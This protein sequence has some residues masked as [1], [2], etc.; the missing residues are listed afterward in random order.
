MSNATQ[1]LARSGAWPAL[2]TTPHTSDAGVWVMPVDELGVATMIAARNQSAALADRIDRL[3]GARLPAEPRRVMAAA[4]A[5]V[6]VGP[7]VWLATSETGASSFAAMLAQQV[8]DSA[9]VSDQT[10]A[11]SVLRIGG[12]RVRSALCKLVPIDMHS[13]AFG[14]GNAAVTVAA[15]IGVTLWRLADETS[16]SSVFELAVPRSM[17]GSF[18]EAFF[19]S[20]AEL[21]VRLAAD[22]PGATG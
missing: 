2:T 20:S 19:A 1:L 14:I 18:W 6:G 9:S 4:T 17:A 7:G 11:Y 21:G 3:F 8:G 12:A 5:F 15:H 10:D 22:G 16:G 13:R